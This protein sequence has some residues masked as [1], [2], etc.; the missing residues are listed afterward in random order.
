M[1]LL[2]FRPYDFNHSEY[3]GFQIHENNL[4]VSWYKV[5]CLINKYGKINKDKIKELHSVHWSF[6]DFDVS[7]YEQ[8]ISQENIKIMIGLNT[9]SLKEYSI[10]N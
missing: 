2:L 3:S 5:L 6:S 9:K 4:F 10:F 8:K 1:P 7:K